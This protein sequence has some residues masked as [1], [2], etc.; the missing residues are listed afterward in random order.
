MK[1]EDIEK[2]FFKKHGYV[3]GGMYFASLEFSN[4]CLPC[5]WCENLQMLKSRIKEGFIPKS[6]KMSYK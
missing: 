6:V 2:P 3:Y 5:I 4:V 1:L